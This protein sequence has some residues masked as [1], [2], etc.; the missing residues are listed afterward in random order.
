M[1]PMTTRWMLACASMSLIAILPACR[2]VDPPCTTYD[3]M[4]GNCFDTA[5]S[6]DDSRTMALDPALL[7]VAP[8]ACH[9]PVLVRVQYVRDGDTLDVLGVTDTSFMGGVRLIGVD[10]PEVEHPPAPADCF[11][12]EARLFTEQLDERLVW[13][14]FDADCYDP[15][16]RWLAYAWVGGGEGDLWQ[17]QLQR[18]GFSRSLTIAPNDANAE[19]FA[20]DAMSALSADRGLWSACTM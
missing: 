18:R 11:G 8:G 1:P 5:I 10:C 15:F 14:T 4:V 12:N 2:R 16:D 17:R 13:L 19:L 6:L 7:P 3:P 9:A 20:A